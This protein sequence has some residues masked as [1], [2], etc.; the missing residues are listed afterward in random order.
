[1]IWVVYFAMNV[2]GHIV[3]LWG[4]APAAINYKKTKL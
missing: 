1:M 2:Q 4:K 3:L